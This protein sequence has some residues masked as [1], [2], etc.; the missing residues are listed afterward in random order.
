MKEKIKWVIRNFKSL[1]VYIAVRIVAA[2]IKKDAGYRYSWKSA[3][4]VAFQDEVK[5]IEGHKTIGR[6]D[7]NAISN[8]AAENFLRML[9]K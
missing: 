4:A 3:I 9:T 5:R 8:A 2:E 6:L 7:W 1:H